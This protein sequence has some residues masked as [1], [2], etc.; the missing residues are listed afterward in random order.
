MI[1]DEADYDERLLRLIESGPYEE[2]DG[3]PIK[4]TSQEV[5][6]LTSR[7]AEAFVVGN[8]HKDVEVKR[9]IMRKKLRNTNPR[10]P[11]MYALPKIHK[12][13]ELKLRPIRSSIGDTTEK[14]G[15]WLL[16]EFKKLKPFPSHSVSNTFGFVDRTKDIVLAE[17]EEMVSFDVENLFPS[18]PIETAI[19]FLKIWLEGNNVDKEKAALNV[20][21]AELCMRQSFFTFRGRFFRQTHGTTMG[22]TLSPFIADKFNV[23]FRK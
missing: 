11:R 4:V 18:V 16:Q 21:T 9:W 15:P 10:T 22:N 6:D 7:I 2:I 5:I 14:L 3:D 13:G 1:L 12:P 19:E 8:K 20:E 23:L 17:D